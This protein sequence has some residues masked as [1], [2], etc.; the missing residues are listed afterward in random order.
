M[1]QTVSVKNIRLRMV[2]VTTFNCPMLSFCSALS[3]CQCIAHSTT[4][5]NPVFEPKI[6]SVI[7]VGC[8]PHLVKV[9]GDQ[10]AVIL[11]MTNIS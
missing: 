8:S 11:H 9:T 6:I 1:F 2:V 4:E 5:M 3:N 7:P 10:S